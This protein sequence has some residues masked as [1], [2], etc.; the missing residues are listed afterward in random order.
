LD[1]FVIMPN[2]VHGIL[3]LSP[4]ICASRTGEADVGAAHEPPSSLSMIVGYFKMNAAKRINAHRNTS[5]ARLWQ[6]GFYER[7]VRNDDELFRIREYI[8]SNP[9]SWASDRENPDRVSDRDIYS[10]L[11]G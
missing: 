2:H 7:V 8:A 6:R 5:G 3:F 9:K 10:W 1:A 11:Y 4:R